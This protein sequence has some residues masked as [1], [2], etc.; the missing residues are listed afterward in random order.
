MQF[1]VQKNIFRYIEIVNKMSKVLKN[2]C[3]GPY[4]YIAEDNNIIHRIISSGPTTVY[5]F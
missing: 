1:Y 4:T 2:Q 3:T 5:P